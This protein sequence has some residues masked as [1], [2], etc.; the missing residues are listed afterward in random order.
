MFNNKISTNT[1]QIHVTHY[2]HI[3]KH[4]YKERKEEDEI[5]AIEFGSIKEQ[6]EVKIR[7]L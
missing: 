2:I 4:V 1:R 7:K 5:K 6:P 3:H